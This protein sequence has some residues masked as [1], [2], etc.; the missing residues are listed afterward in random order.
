M[1][2]VKIATAAPSLMWMFNPAVFVTVHMLPL[3]LLRT[4]RFVKPVATVALIIL[5]SSVGSQAILWEEEVDD[6]E[7]RSSPF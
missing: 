6:H 2:P 4:V 7:L 3:P 1:K 5:A